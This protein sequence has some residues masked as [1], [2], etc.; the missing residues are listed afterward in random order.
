[1]N[2]NLGSIDIRTHAVDPSKP[3]SS[4]VYRRPTRLSTPDKSGNYS[5]G[6]IHETVGNN[7]RCSLQ[8]CV[9]PMTFTRNRIVEGCVPRAALRRGWVPQ[10]PWI[11]GI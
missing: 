11:V 5:R 9:S 10:P 2:F 4:A 8:K 3:C 7:D 6:L 1:M